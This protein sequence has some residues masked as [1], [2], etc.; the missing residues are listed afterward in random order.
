MSS[1]FRPALALMSGRILGG[2]A[3]SIVPLILVRLLD[4]TA[5]GTYKQTFL[6]YGTL[7]GIL[8]IGM[9]ESLYYFLPHE[10][11]HAGRFVANS[12]LVLLGA[13]LLGLGLLVISAPAAARA[14]NNPA[15]AEPLRWLGVYL[16]LALVSNVLEI[17]MTARGR[18]L[19]AASSFAVSELLRSTLF[20]TPVLLFG[21]VRS[22]LVGA[23]L[24]ALFRVI[25]AVA[26]LWREYGPEL[27]PDF[28]LLRVQLAYALP[29]AAA[30]VVQIIQENF[31]Q[32][33]VSARFGAAIFAVY[34]VGC[35]QIPLVDFLS[36][37]VSSVMMVKMAEDKAAG[38]ADRVLPHWHDTTRTLALLFCPMVGLLLVNARAIIHVL[39]TERFLASAP[40]LMLWS[41]AFLAAV[42]QIDGVLRVYADTRFLLIMNLC[43]LGLVLLLI[44]P[45]L[46]MFGLPGAVVV[47]LLALFAGKAMALLRIGHLMRIGGRSIL[48]W[49]D[50]A[51]ITGACI[52]A[53]LPALLIQS[54]LPLPPWASLLLTGSVYA[55]SCAILLLL[56]KAVT[57]PRRGLV[58]AWMGRRPGWL[59]GTEPG[60]TL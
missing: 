18:Y 38:R 7:F 6:V 50:L 30:V 17:A 11:R 23:A 31:H 51:R 39:F 56:L 46:S 22:L 45:F 19:L 43:R 20:V 35:L 49:F 41:L 21:T 44:R 16:A 33:A 14:M 26:W 57:L 2:L 34:A 42:F 59:P 1:S 55:A 28:A 3:A 24:F 32:Y 13:G 36:T 5:F 54:G 9:A 15:L 37:S 52:G 40:I 12:L 10:A 4:P 27:R 25:A 29:F 47:T 53:L 60:G 58:G 48:P 8:Q